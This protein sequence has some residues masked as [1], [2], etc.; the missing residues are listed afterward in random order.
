MTRPK[1]R[2]G[3]QAIFSVKAR[4]GKK[5]LA[6]YLAARLGVVETWAAS[7]IDAGAV[8]LDGRKAVAGDFINL[9]AG[10]HSIEIVF[11][12]SWPRHM[13]A[14]E[15]NLELLHEDDFLAILNKPP[16]IV[17]HPARGHLDGQ[18]LQ[19][20]LRHRYRHLIGLQETTIGAPHRLDKDTS[21]VVVFALKRDAYIELVRQF[22]AGEPKKEYW[23]LL[24]GVPAFDNIIS[25][26]AIGVDPDLPKRG[27]LMPESVGGKAAE[28]EFTVLER[29]NGIS[30]VLARP[31]TGRSHQ[32][33][34]HAAGLG[35]PVVGDLDYHPEPWRHGAK[36]QALHAA[37]LTITHP[38]TGESRR[39]EAPL[40]DD[41]R[42]LMLAGGMRAL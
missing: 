4:S 10:E 34:L 32:I 12:E 25:R 17:V 41:M 29:G 16:G 8:S 7:L 37:S 9:S 3:E 26:E 23:A 35:F 22:T 31:R 40:P 42:R 21:G 28:T 13:A 14:T 39:F 2:P 38:A 20:G 11:P 19:N 15:M 33:R 1:F 24:D 36:R 6:N 30:L 27:K 18:T 5:L